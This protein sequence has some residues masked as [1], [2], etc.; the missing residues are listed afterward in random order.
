FDLHSL[1]G[2]II[3]KNPY[4]WTA[5]SNLGAQLMRENK[6]EEAVLWFRRAMD[7]DEDKFITKTNY[8]QALFDLGVQHGFEPGQ[9]ED[10]IDSFEDALR[11]E[12]RWVN[13]RVG[14][15]RALIRAKD[16]DRAKR[17]LTR[18][19]EER[20]EHA[21]GLAVMGSLNVAEKDWPAAEQFFE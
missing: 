20:P 16:Y 3:E 4:S 1:Y 21:L 15:G 12:P 7:I 13:S 2:D 11:L 19:L 18:A 6:R 10:V 9:L 14:L 8:G 17:E 5:M